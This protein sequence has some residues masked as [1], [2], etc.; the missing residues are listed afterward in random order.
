MARAVA[1]LCATMIEEARA[2]NRNQRNDLG[3]ARGMGGERGSPPGIGPMIAM[4]RP[5]KSNASLARDRGDDGDEWNRQPRQEAPT[6][7]DRADRQR[8]EP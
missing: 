8:G 3:P 4:P 2:R 7:E 6:G 1:A 5:A